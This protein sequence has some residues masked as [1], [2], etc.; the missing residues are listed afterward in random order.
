M[1]LHV[2][3]FRKIFEAYASIFISGTVNKCY[4]RYVLIPLS[5]I[6]LLLIYCISL[7][8]GLLRYGNVLSWYFRGEANNSG[9]S[10]IS[11]TSRNNE[12]WSATEINVRIRRLLTSFC[13]WAATVI[14][15]SG[16]THN[17]W[18][19]L[20][21]PAPPPRTTNWLYLLD[22][23]QRH[24]H[25]P[26]TEDASRHGT[27]KYIKNSGVLGPTVIISFD[28]PDTLSY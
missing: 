9:I 12:A 17:L 25:L 23:L 7:N 2:V 22:T 18:W 16:P 4:I 28:F 19:P 14:A 20:F 13:G 8:R 10:E 26:R 15:V 6:A 11:S 3:L 5:N 21:R 27:E 24:R 1:K